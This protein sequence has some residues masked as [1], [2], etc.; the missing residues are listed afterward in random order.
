MHH[1]RK[2][3]DLRARLEI[4][5]GAALCHGFEPRVRPPSAQGWFNL[6]VPFVWLLNWCAQKCV[7]DIL[8]VGSNTVSITNGGTQF[9]TLI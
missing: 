7:F 9:I 4:T 2:A 8:I 3:D 5:K 6:T 1:H